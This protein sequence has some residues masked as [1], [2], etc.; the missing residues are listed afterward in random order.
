MQNQTTKNTEKAVDTTQNRWKSKYLWAA[1]LAQVLSILVLTG[2]IDT[3]L[4]GAI[5]GIIA[6]VLQVLVAVGVLN[7]P[8]DAQ[9]W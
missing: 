8:T 6:S 1:L 5:E 7:N 2:V 9:N 3:G 4:S